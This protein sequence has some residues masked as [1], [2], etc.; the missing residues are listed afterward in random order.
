MHCKFAAFRLLVV[1]ISLAAWFLASNHCAL[2]VPPGIAKVTES[3]QCPMHVHKQQAPQ[4]D[5]G[6]GCGDL[7]CCKDLQTPLAI[8]AKIIAKPMWL[9][10]LQPFFSQVMGT[11]GI[12]PRT[13]AMVLET[14]P[15]GAL[16]FCEAVLQRSILAH[17]PPAVS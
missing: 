11:F 5:K 2:A 13:I 6:N 3:S 10:D 1:A 12:Q 14:G 4:H 8:T 17:A 15:P 9:G 16:S 7:P